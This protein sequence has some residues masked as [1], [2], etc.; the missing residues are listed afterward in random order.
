MQSNID[1]LMAILD[2]NPPGSAARINAL[3]WYARAEMQDAEFHLRERNMGQYRACCDR[4][5]QAHR[6]IGDAASNLQGNR[7]AEVIKHFKQSAHE[8]A[9]HQFTI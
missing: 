6:L 2:A 7:A 8:G 9:L 5:A 4:S 3:E 1:E